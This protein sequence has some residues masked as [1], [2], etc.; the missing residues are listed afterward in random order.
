MSSP[1]VLWFATDLGIL[2]KNRVQSRFWVVVTSY[3]DATGKC[4][5]DCCA[6]YVVSPSE[7]GGLGYRPTQ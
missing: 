2:P 7:S 4:A 6:N 3:R 1:V 5:G